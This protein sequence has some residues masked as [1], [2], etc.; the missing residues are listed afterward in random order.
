MQ[1]ITIKVNSCLEYICSR[2]NREEER[3]E[4]RLYWQKAQASVLV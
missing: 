2:Y 1:R 4:W 3:M